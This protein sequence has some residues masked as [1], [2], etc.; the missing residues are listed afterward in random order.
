MMWLFKKGY[1][2]LH[3]LSKKIFTFSLL[4]FFFVSTALSQSI[5]VTGKIT[6][7]DN[8]QAL[9]GVNVTIEGTSI[10]AATDS[11]GHYAIE[12]PSSKATLLFSHVGFAIQKIEVGNRSVIDVHLI[13]DIKELEQ[14]VV[15]GY[16]TTRKKDL[17]GSVASVALN[18]QEKTPVLGT[19]Q[20]L[21]GKVSG[22]EVTQNQ[23]QPGAVFSV[24]IRGTNS[25]NASSGPLYVIDGY[26]G[27]DPGYL[28]PSDILSIDVLKDAS[29]TAIYGSRGANGV[30]IITTKRGSKT[31]P[32]VTL[33]A[34]TGVQQVAKQYKMMDAKQFGS[35]LNTVQQERNELN[36]TSDALPYTQQQID[37][38]GKGTD[39][40]NEIF[41]VAPISNYSIAFNGGDADTK[42][43]L[44]LNFF[45]QQGI[46]RG[47]DFK[48]AIVRYNLDLNLSNKLKAGIS[49]QLGYSYQKMTAVNTSGGADQ[50]SVLWD[51]VRFN[52]I[53]APRDSSGAYTYVNGPAGAVLPLGNPVAYINEAKDESY[54]L[55]IFTNVFGEYEIIK[56]LKIRSSFGT[57]YAINGGE[58]FLPTDLFYAPGVGRAS[59]YTARY[60]NWLNENT[61]TYDREF[62]KI[63][64]INVTG[65]FTFQHWYDK[66]FFAGITNLSTN[67]LGADNLGVG[68]AIPPGS[69]YG[70]NTLASYFTRVNYRLMDKYLF[71][72]TMRADG[73]SRFGANDKWGYFPSG[74]FAWHL[75]EENFIKKSKAISDM[76]LRVSYGI[77]GNQE[78]GSYNSL[79]QYVPVSYAL[80]STPVLAVGQI[81]N[82]IANPSL[83]WESTSS[84]DI[85]LD[86]GLWNNRVYF[87]TDF[88]YKKTSDLL[89]F[90]NIPATSG[91]N[92][93]LQN[94]GAVSNKGFEFSATTLNIDQKKI[95]WSTTLNFSA[96]ANKVLNL[97]TNPQIYVG[98]LS[99]SVFN[100]GGGTS[101]ILVPGKPIGSFYGYVFDGIWQSQ[102]QINKS[103]TTQA[104]TPGDPIYKDLNN[105]SLLSGDD[106]MILGQA[107][108][109]FIYSFTNNFTFGRFNLNVFLQG[110]YGNKIFN[111]NLYEIQNGT[112]DF[113][114]LAYVAT[115]SWHGA[116]TSNTLPRVSS[117]LRNS[118]GVTSDVIEDGSFLRVKTITLSYDLPLTKHSAVFKSA[119]VY[120]TAQNLLTITNYSGYDPEVNSFT[121]SNALSLGTDY[122][123]FPNY[124]NLV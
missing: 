41:Q 93:I 101:A 110:V 117:I 45:D 103:G 15:I 48:R 107:R 102:E 53:L 23:S 123:A 90:I 116:G 72:V 113:N 119:N 71:T 95:K 77:T 121:D 79:S 1:F 42:H 21:Q 120:I 33:D 63:H 52:P 9:K 114:K 31:A 18:D 16:G 27:G 36:G 65:G 74:A 62:N 86:V 61:L 14:V 34:Y 91:Y 3:L 89:L 8:G 29:A 26:A 76:K 73:S 108:P 51:A 32:K 66:S 80:G 87:T 67:N 96:N 105:D 85:G 88:Y 70:E 118:I 39:W 69:F 64:A 4:L 19:E 94:I 6:A 30:I 50:P 55:S 28:N 43:Y 112:P 75:S 56:G 59:Q 25:I 46:I 98:D 111:E 57:N 84:S 35:F 12:A 99:G 49:S 13:S 106:R 10:G 24:R 115:D 82:N 100:G 54:N 68:I 83:K 17:T 22:V 97:G 37:A 20:L 92:S 2:G 60:Y 109:K 78:I 7:L 11:S 122:N 81:P 58:S 47:S 38:L 104:V 44:S 5:K 40:Q 124:P